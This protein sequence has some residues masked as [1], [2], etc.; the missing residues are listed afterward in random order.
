MTPLR[1]IIHWLPAVLA[2][3]FVAGCGEE[4]KQ[5]EAPPPEVDVAHPLKR[6]IVEWDEYTG[7]FEATEEVDIRARVTGYLVKKQFRDGQFVKQGDVLYVI[8]QRPFE[9]EVKRAQA[10]Y[11]LAEK[12]HERAKSLL[13][14]NAISE[15]ELDMSLQ[16]LQVA[17]AALNEAQ[18]NLEFTT[19]TAPIDGKISESFVDTGNLVRENDTLLTRIVSVAP[20]HFTFEVSQGELLKYARLDQS[21]ERPGDGANPNPLF[22][23]LQDEDSYA[24]RGRIDFVDNEVDEGTGSITVRALVGNR[25]GIL[26]PGLFGRARLVGSGNYEAT[27]LP[28][29]TIQTDQHRKFV[30]IVN[31]A[32]QTERAY[33]KLGPVLDNGLIIIREGLTGA[34]RV[35]INGVVRI[36]SAEQDVTPVM[37]TIEWQDTEFMPSIED[38]PSLEEIQIG[39]L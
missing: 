12:V 26:Q 17:E 33:L 31:D 10:Q 37:E 28:E 39:Q 5:A 1:T 34:E 24:H 13:D 32:N 23:R 8:D 18:L 19:I 3:L 20:I 25:N 35:V 16:E 15:Q 27:L 36:R 11:A 29:H 6:R 4:V 21:G 30:Y 9:F 2:A 22:V 14:S 7:R 38:I